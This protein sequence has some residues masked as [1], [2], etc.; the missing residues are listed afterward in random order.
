MR[1]RVCWGAVIFAGVVL[2][3]SSADAQSVSPSPSALPERVGSAPA[4]VVAAATTTPQTP[5][6]FPAAG[7]GPPVGGDFFLHRW[8]EDWRGVRAAGAAPPLKAIALGGELSASISGEARLRYDVYDNASATRGND[9]NQA[10]FRGVLGAD[11]RYG[12]HLRVFGEV[13]TGQIEGRKDAALAS[14]QNDASLQQLFL[15]VQGR[16][17]SV[18]VGAIIGRQEFTD[19]SRALMGVSDGP[20]LHRSWNGLRLY[21]HG[22]RWRAG[23]FDLRVTRL[24]S[25]GFGDED[26]NHADRLQGVNASLLLSRSE[27]GSNIYL[28]PFWMHTEYGSYRVGGVLGPDKR[29]TVGAR[30]WS[31]RGRLAIDWTAASQTGDSNGRDVSAWALFLTQT[32]QVTN[33]GW[34]PR[35][36]VRID[37]GSGGG[38][39]TGGDVHTFNQLYENQSYLGEGLFLSPSNLLLVS[40]NL[41]VSPTPKLTMSAEY[42]FARRINEHDAAYAGLSRPYAGTQGVSGHEIGGLF[43]GV[44]NYA[45]NDRLSVMLN[46]EKFRAGEVLD[47]AGQPGG[48]Y[49]YVGATF[50]Y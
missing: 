2:A 14:F 43:R 45:V 26:I 10:L 36:G 40:P 28:D 20:N 8:V 6:P 23:A 24:G 37:V 31:R 50:R 22:E 25:S 7:W 48:A 17:D 39:Y 15:E 12:D 9:Y 30:L 35:L 42:G 47:R 11:V 4:A 29:D 46:V 16:V 18:L 32:V 38:S 49:A 5:Y 27:R 33:T 21:A 41:S 3:A 34:K 19:G 1:Q 44:V 13:G